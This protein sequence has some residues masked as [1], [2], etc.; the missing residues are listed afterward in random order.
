MRTI[1]LSF[2]VLVSLAACNTGQQK[3]SSAIDA[4]LQAKA[5]S[6]LQEKLAEFDASTGQII[7]M[8]VQTGEVKASVGN[9]SLLQ[10]SGLVRTAVLLAALETKSVSLSDTVNVGNGVL[11]VDNDTLYD[12]N[13]RRGG[14]GRITLEQGFASSSDIAI[15]KTMKKAFKNG[16]ALAEALGKLGY[17]VEDSSLVR[18]LSGYGILT[19]PLQNLTFITSKAVLHNPD[20]R[21]ALEYAVTDGLGRPAQ[22]QMVKVAG[23]TSTLLLPDGEYALEFCG[24]FPADNPEYSM[25]VTLNKEGLPASGGLMAGTVFKELAE[26]MVGEWKR[27]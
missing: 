10:A 6:V 14:Y 4:D 19:T 1:F 11:I 12:H 3:Q 25:I 9:D 15:Y 27:P 7:I 26:Y 21:Q 5:D 8:D 17:Q 13:W 20:M 18:D 24:Y 23:V 16:Q 22:S 2:I